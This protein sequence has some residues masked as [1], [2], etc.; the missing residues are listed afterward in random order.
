MI[1]LRRVLVEDAIDEDVAIVARWQR[2][3]VDY[4]VLKSECEA[5][6]RGLASCGVNMKQALTKKDKEAVQ[7]AEPE[8]TPA[9]RGSQHRRAAA[10]Q[11]ELDAAVVAMEKVRHP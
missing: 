7:E 4:D 10:Q 5:I 9:G 6:F 2:L 1:Y 8:K 11:S 3:M